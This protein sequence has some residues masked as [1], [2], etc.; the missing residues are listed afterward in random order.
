[1][2]P[3]RLAKY[4]DHTLLSQSATRKDF[5][6][7]CKEAKAINCASVCVPPSMVRHV[8]EQLKGS[9][10]KVCT[11]IG[12]PLGFQTGKV[13][14]EEALKA[15]EDGADELDMVIN[16]SMVKDKRFNEILAEIA[17]VKVNT[18]YTPL[19]VIIET[20]LLTDKEKAKMC[21]LVGQSGAD[22][23]KTST[24]LFGGVTVGDMH[25]IKNN[26]PPHLNI[27]ASGG[28]RT[29]EDAEQYIKLGASR[30]GT[31][32]VGKELYKMRNDGK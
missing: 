27:K 4:I 10:V 8:A 13:K 5:T 16:I 6:N 31:S 11:V 22:Y 24:G 18:D 23:V 2:K 30:I 25:I 29:I 12:F 1:M 3:K 15:K 32:S 20:G 7:L 19:K 17:N 26:I 21:E 14:L 9:P 28:I